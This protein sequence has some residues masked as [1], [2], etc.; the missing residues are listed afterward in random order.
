MNARIATII[1]L[2][3]EFGTPDYVKG[4]G[5][6]TSVKNE[7]TLWIKPSGST[8]GGLSAETLV[9]IDRSK[10]QAL[11]AWTPPDDVKAREASVKDQMMAVVRPGSEGRPS[12]ETPM[13][14]C[15]SATFVVHTH[16]TLVNGMTC[17]NDG[18]AFCKEF[19]P[20]ALWLDYV[21]PGYV[22]SRKVHEEVGEYARRHGRQPDVIFLENHGLVVAGE[23]AEEIRARHAMILD[24]IRR[25]YGAKGLST[26]LTL[27]A[28]PSE[29]S[30]ERFSK[31]IE[32]IPDLQG[33]VLSA[34]GKFPVADGPI[35]PDHIVYSKSYAL[36]TE[37]DVDTITEFK[38]VHGYYPQV[39]ECAVGVFGIGPTDAKAFLAVD[40][41][42]D[43]ALIEQLAPAFGG[44][45]YLDDGA[46]D[47]IDNWEVEAFRRQVKL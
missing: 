41:A 35:S 2:S 4:G 16:P 45:Q 8:L 17:A 6:N 7:S 30:R 3:H 33:S 1:A 40:L 36:K 18:A 11:Y 38:K 13:H 25:E 21:D 47:F 12:V 19:F 14:D 46:R 26:E 42:R 23:T 9:E 31:V 5:G 44:I 43:G 27:G 32:S 28:P 20:D 39:A 29:D 22:L 10:L 37:P 24:R 34:S 15:L